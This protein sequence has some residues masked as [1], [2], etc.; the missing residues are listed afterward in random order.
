MAQF[1]ADIQGQAGSASRLGS[2]RSGI[3]AHVRG[4]HSGVKV[5]GYVDHNGADVFA[6]YVTSGS[7]GAYSDTELG[8]VRVDD[9]GQAYFAPSQ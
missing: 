5:R 2:P 3:S 9:R 6:V 1:K 4:W 8:A 7:H